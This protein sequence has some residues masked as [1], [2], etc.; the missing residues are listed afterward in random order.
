MSNG[1]QTFLSLQSTYNFKSCFDNSVFGFT[2]I[3]LYIIQYYD[4]HSF[5]CCFLL[6][7][8]RRTA[9]TNT[10]WMELLFM[11]NCF[12]FISF[13]NSQFSYWL[14]D[15]QQ[16]VHFEYQTCELIVNTQYFFWRI[17]WIFRKL[18]L[19][20]WYFSFVKSSSTHFNNKFFTS[21]VNN[22]L[23]IS[24]EFVKGSSSTRIINTIPK[25][26]CLPYVLSVL[27]LWSETF[28]VCVFKLLLKS[29]IIKVVKYFNREQ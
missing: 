4:Q 22:S 12:L 13:F 11:F 3:L 20:N 14:I 21:Y 6:Q 25:Y 1:L 8:L 28:I 10:S 7:F 27:L 18:F 15:G 9:I 2:V 29:D 16:T 5:Y 24:L 23:K 19:K 17:W 26:W